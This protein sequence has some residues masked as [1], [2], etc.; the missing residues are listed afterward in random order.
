M[1][2]ASHTGSKQG[3]RPTPQLTVKLFFS[4]LFIFVLL[5]LDMCSV[6]SLPSTHFGS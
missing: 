3:L 6:F 4:G 2:Y 1:A 5:H